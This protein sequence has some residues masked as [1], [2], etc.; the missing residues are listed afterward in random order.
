MLP[1]ASRF[2]RA[3]ETGVNHPKDAQCLCV[4]LLLAHP[5]VLRNDLACAIQSRSFFCKTPH[6]I[7]T[8]RDLLKVIR[9]TRIKFQRSLEIL[10]RFI[11]TALSS[12]DVAE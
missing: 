10:Q 11:P 9:I 5:S 7:K 3:A 1:F 2:A 6:T 4:L 12:I 8:A